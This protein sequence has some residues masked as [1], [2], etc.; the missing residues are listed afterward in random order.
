MVQKNNAKKKKKPKLTDW[1]SIIYTTVEL[2]STVPGGRRGQRPG[3][4]DEAWHQ[5]KRDGGG[6]D[7]C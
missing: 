5:K 7:H 2:D 4:A 1:Q 3:T 6:G